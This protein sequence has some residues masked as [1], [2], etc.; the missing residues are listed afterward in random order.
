MST[1]DSLESLTVEQ[2]KTLLEE[3]GLPKSGKKAELIERLS[4][5]DEK[6]VIELGTSVWSR[7]VVGQFNLAQTVGSVAAASSSWWSCSIP[8]SLDSEKTSLCT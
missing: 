5:P 2:L 6:N 1:E 7:T 3:R 8:Q 4:V